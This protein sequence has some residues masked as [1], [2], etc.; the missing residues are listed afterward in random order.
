MV[1]LRLSVGLSGF[2]FPGL[3]MRGIRHFL[4]FVYLTAIHF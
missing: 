2:S 1:W 3:S 4:S